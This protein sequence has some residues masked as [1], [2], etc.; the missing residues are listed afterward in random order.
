M[1]CTLTTQ[2]GIRILACGFVA[3]YAN[4]IMEALK[5]IGS[6]YIDMWPDQARTENNFDRQ[7]AADLVQNQF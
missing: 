5:Y 1:G 3:R 6:S 2:A 4:H 7:T